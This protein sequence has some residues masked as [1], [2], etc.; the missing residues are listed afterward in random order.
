MSQH[1][2]IGKPA[3]ALCALLSHASA[4]QA[5]LSVEDLEGTITQNGEEIGSFVGALENIEFKRQGR[6]IVAVGDLTGEILDAAGETVREIS[7]QIKF[8]LTDVGTEEPTPGNCQVLFL[9]LGPLALN[10]L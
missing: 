3:L 9:D 1:F 8:P 2:A 10:L 5:Q 4:A 7:R 6:Q